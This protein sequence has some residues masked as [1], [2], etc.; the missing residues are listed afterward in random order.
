MEAG[1]G[2]QA[3]L[4]APAADRPLA[5]PPGVPAAAALPQYFC[6]AVSLP[7]PRPARS[8]AA[9]GAASAGHQ[10]VPAFHAAAEQT[11]ML[12]CA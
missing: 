7:T 2:E 9:R 8:R 12:A 4:P 5:L 6:V 1:E 10:R 11:A 3:G